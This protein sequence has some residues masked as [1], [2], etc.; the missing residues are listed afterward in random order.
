MPLFEATVVVEQN[1]SFHMSRLLLLI[2]TFAGSNRLGTVEGI[3]KLAKLDFL[4]RYPS[5]LERAMAARGV[6][7]R[8]ANVKSFEKRNIESKMV[9]F[10]Y[11]PWD[12]RY[13]RLLNLLVAK[14][15]VHIAV[16]GRTVHIGITQLGHTTAVRL[17]EDENFNDLKIR[18]RLLKTHF[19][20]SGTHLMR[21]IYRTFPE[22]FTLKYGEVIG[23]I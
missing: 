6:N 13:R 18:S 8:L 5:N 19:E 21:F 15:L 20:M 3:T 4:L 22:L 11:G 17:S 16:S 1:D 12:F 23:E 9:R 10:K 2:D 7:P 14:G